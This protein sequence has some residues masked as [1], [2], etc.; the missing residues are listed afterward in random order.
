LVVGSVELVPLVDA[1]G[2]L[3]ELDELYPGFDGWE[4]YR[5][6]YPDLF[7]GSQWRITCTSYLLRSGRDRHRLPDPPADR[8]RGW[9]T[10]RDAELV[11]PSA[12]YIPTATP[13]PS[14]A[15]DRHGPPDR[16]GRL[17]GSLDR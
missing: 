16:V 10:D 4:P 3:G 2:L 9:N 6:L 1:V 11:F 7:A 13:S 14:R 5:A 15:G 12:R 8:P 17:G